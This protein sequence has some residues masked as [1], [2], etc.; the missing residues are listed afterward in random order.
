MKKKKTYQP[1]NLVL[2]Y[3]PLIFPPHAGITETIRSNQ[4]KRLQVLNVNI[5]YVIAPGVMSLQRVFLPGDTRVD[6]KLY[7]LVECEIK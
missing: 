1:V 5:S 6:E 4:R 7:L 3:Y 2:K